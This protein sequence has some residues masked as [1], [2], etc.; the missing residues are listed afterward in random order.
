L[1]RVRELFA[2]NTGSQNNRK[3]STLRATTC[4]LLTTAA[5]ELHKRILILSLIVIIILFFFSLSGYGVG[6]RSELIFCESLSKYLSLGWRIG[7]FTIH[8]TLGYN[9]P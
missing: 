2:K 8:R 6:V 9:N 4:R 5:K 7:R 1:E 3:R